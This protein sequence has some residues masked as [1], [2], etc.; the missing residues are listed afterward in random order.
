MAMAK[1]AHLEPSK[2][3]LAFRVHD[4]RFLVSFIPLQLSFKEYP[5]IRRSLVVAVRDVENG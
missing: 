1:K 2:Q 5:Y 3:K 4:I